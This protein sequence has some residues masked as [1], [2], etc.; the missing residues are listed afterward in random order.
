MIQELLKNKTDGEKANIKGLEIAKMS[1]GARNNVKFS[2]ADYD[3]EIIGMNPIKGGV[4][5]FAKAW[6]QNGQIGF[7]VDGTID[8]ERFVI[9]NPPILVTDLNGDIIREYLDEHVGET[10][11]RKLREDPIL[12][13]L[14]SLTH[15]ISVKKQ[16]FDDRRIVKGKIGNTTLTAYPNASTGTAPIDSI[17]HQTGV[18]ATFATLTAG[19]GDG[20]ANTIAEV[21]IWNLRDDT[22]TNTYTLLRR[23]G[24]G[25]DTSSIAT[26][27]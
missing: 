8:I 22:T 27:N 23:G 12:A 4:E 25:F 2:G 10:K 24:F 17:L 26:D 20:N 14:Q 13:I 1:F 9:I 3:I 21:S 19:A 18:A 7:G 6:D 16:K 11:Q 15:T 5:V